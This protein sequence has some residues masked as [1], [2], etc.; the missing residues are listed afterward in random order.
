MVINHS[1]ADFFAKSRD[2]L[3]IYESK[4]VT[5]KGIFLFQNGYKAEIP[6]L[7]LLYY[8]LTKNNHHNTYFIFSYPTTHCSIVCA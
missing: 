4:A 5:F 6:A 2:L 7:R 8:L 1:A 3:Y